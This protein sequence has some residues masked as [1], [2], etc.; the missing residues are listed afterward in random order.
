MSGTNRPTLGEAYYMPSLRIRNYRDFIL[1]LCK[2]DNFCGHLEQIDPASC[3]IFYYTQI[4]SVWCRCLSSS[5][6]KLCSMAE[7]LS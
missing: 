5:L 6:S 2:I 1:R 4:Q 3:L 7:N